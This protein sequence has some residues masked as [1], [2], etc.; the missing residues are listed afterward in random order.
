MRLIGRLDHPHII[1]AYDA[2]RVDSAFF[3]VMEYAGGQSLDRV[4]QAR[5]PLPHAEVVD[6]AAQAALGLRTPT[7]TGSSTGTSSPR[8]CS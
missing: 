2:D 5:G 1:R 7:S 4:L 8:T 3:L 6:Y